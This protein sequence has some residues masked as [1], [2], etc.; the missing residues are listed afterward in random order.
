M[1][2]KYKAIHINSIQYH[3]IH[4]IIT[5]DSNMHFYIEMYMIIITLMI[6]MC[7]NHKKYYNM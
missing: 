6:N 7:I 5:H 1:S 3:F 4:V 2:Y